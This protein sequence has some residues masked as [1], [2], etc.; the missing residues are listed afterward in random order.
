[1]FHPWLV[2]NNTTF[3]IILYFDGHTSRISLLLSEFCREKKIVLI[4]L[5]AN[6]THI[7]QPLDVAFFKPLKSA[8]ANAATDY[9]RKNNLLSIQKVQFGS[10][11]ETI[12]KNMNVQQCLKNGFSTCGLHP[13]DENALEYGNVFSRMEHTEHSK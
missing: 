11:L 10:I 5:K 12:L 3:P 7:L 4:A 1:M 9:C 2:A 6:A 8:W 13:F